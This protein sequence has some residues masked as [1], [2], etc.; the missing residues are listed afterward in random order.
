MT[1]SPCPRCRK[2]PRSVE[3]IRD[4]TLLLIADDEDPQHLVLE[5]AD[6]PSTSSAG[7]S[8][9]GDSVA[10]PHFGRG[11]VLGAI[12]FGPPS[13]YLSCRDCWI[14]WDAQAREQNRHR[15]IGLSRLLIRPEVHCANLASRCYRLAL[16]QVRQDW[17]GPLRRSARVGRDL[18]GP[19]HPYR[20]LPGRRQLA[21]YRAEP[22]AGAAPVP[23]G[24]FGLESVKDVWVWQ[25]E[26]Q[27]RARLQAAR[28]AGRRAPFDLQP[29]PAGLLGGGRTGRAGPGPRQTPSTLCP[30]APGP[31]GSS[32]LEFLYQLR[33][34]AGGKAAYA[35]IAKWP[36]RN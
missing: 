10:L 35:F 25:W 18:C 32:R 15:V 14:G 4:L 6:Q 19:Q 16:R 2:V 17:F 26:R 29:Q 31:L 8:F 1:A 23:A 13:F 27:A 11:G 33:R 9:D 30:D 22:R 28:L 24:T 7:R 21:S 12:G 36:G 34:S 3:Q 5:S 20:P